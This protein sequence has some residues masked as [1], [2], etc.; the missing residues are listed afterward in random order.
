MKVLFVDHPEADYLAS[1]LYMGLCELLGDDNVVD[2]PYKPSYHG[3]LH[4]YPSCYEHT[5]ACGS[6]GPFSWSRPSAGRAW[7]RDEVI[8]RIKE[9]DLV[10]L[11]SPRKNS[12]RDLRD[13]VGA[14][15]LDAM[16]PR[17]V[18]DGEDYP[19]IRWD[20][21][22]EFEAQRCFK[23]ELFADS[24]GRKGVFGGPRPELQDALRPLPFA[25]T[26]ARRPE[27]A[28]DIDVLFLGGGT[29][30]GRYEV[31]AALQSD[32]G[33]QF[34]GGV[35]VTLDLAG[36]QDALSRSKIGISIRGFGYDTMRFWDVPSFDT[37]LLA[38]RT[39][40]LKPHPF[41]DGEHAVYYDDT[42]HLLR[43][44]R[45]LLADDGTRERIARAGNAHLRAHH[46]P[47]AR[48]AYLIKESLR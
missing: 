34:V 35:G 22:S 24:A 45:G 33:A 10:V 1:M 15:G 44:V 17:A 48:A 2:Y 21:Y 25:S 43:Q 11:A 20:L 29:W 13:L 26:M 16:P 27:R 39:P 9:F 19:D 40:L 18:V 28:K 6:T 32:L 37:L 14:I 42:A 46:T 31:C 12:I 8:L 3:V 47:K 30:P 23:R 36:Y 4:T 7:G 38:D 41:V 5:E